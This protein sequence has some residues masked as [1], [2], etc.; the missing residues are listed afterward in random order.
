[1]LLSSR[2]GDP[3]RPRVAPASG[4]IF[5]Q[6]KH[7]TDEL[8]DK[9]YYYILGRQGLWGPWGNPER[10]RSGIDGFISHRDSELV[11]Q[12]AQIGEKIAE[13]DFYTMWRIKP[14]IP[15]PTDSTVVVAPDPSR[16][17]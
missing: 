4:A 12:V 13:T 6:D 5:V 8:Y 16:R 10:Y 11:G 2:R 14:R 17:N 9:G 15:M 1:M 3:R 7:L